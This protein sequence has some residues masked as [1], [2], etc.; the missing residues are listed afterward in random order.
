M[1]LIKKLFRNLFC[2]HEYNL[3]KEQLIQNG[4]NKMWAYQCCKC[5]KENYKML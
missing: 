4:I 5:Q 2:E 3:I 1:K